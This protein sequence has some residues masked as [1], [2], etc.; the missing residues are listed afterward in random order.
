M[1]DLI[2]QTLSNYEIIKKIG[3]GGMSDVYLA[4]QPSIGRDGVFK[5]LLCDLAKK[6]D[7]FL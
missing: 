3:E 5:V 6:E 2:G 7:S 4:K 1:Q